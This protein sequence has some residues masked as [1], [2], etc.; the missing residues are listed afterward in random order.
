MW[1]NLRSHLSWILCFVGVAAANPATITGS[2]I[3]T[4]V[5]VVVV[6]DD[7]VDVVDVV[8]SSFFT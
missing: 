7:T 2:I 8:A 6:D 1:Y 4:V 5:I 3:A